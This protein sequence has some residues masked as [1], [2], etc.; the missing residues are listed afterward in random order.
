MAN[1]WISNSKTKY[2]YLY[3]ISFFII[4]ILITF[5][6]FFYNSILENQKNDLDKQILEI[7]QN[8]SSV[9]KDK[10]LQI[11]SLLELNKVTI[12]SY[13][14]INNISSY[15]NHM[16][17]IRAKYMLNMDWFSLSNGDLKTRVK[18]ISDDNS[19]AYVKLVNFFN[20]Y[21]LD[22]KSLFK[23]WSISSLEWMDEISFDLN[24]SIKK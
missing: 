11:Y 18:V 22:E 10:N 9:E 12:S 20:K 4:S 1:I 23:L 16:N 5:L 7:K 19:I 21:K 15:I 24:M 2:P 13:E 17:V 8:I 14:K 6:L 3:S